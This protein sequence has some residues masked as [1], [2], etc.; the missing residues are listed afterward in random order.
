MLDTRSDVPLRLLLQECSRRRSAVREELRERIAGF[1][2]IAIVMAVPLYSV[3]GSGFSLVES[4]EAAETSTGLRG[5]T[6]PLVNQAAVMSRLETDR[7]TRS[8]IRAIQTQLK[9]N[10]F[11]PGAIDGVAGKRTLAALNAYRQAVRLAPVQAVSREAV[12]QLQIP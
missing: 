9:L 7:L 11:D 8:D 2:A 1:L 4:S 6:P 10:G 3:V 12:G 5:F